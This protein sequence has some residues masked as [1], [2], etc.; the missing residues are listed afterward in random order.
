[1]IRVGWSGPGCKWHRMFWHARRAGPGVA[2]TR[3]VTA[4]VTIRSA[5]AR[6]ITGHGPTLTAMSLAQAARHAHIEN[7][8]SGRHRPR[9]GPGC[10]RD[11]TRNLLQ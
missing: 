11:L 10:R 3:T 8:D 7:R 2:G 4:A 1:M 5:A 6:M 9:A